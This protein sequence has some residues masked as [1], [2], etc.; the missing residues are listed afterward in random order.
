MIG[1]VAQHVTDGQT[2]RNAA[3]VSRTAQ[4]CYADAR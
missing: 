1:S 3:A 4:L 2:D